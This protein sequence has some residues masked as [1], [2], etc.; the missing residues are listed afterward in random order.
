MKL[1]T[2]SRYGV[3][4]MLD[5]ALHADEGPVRLGVVAQRQGIGIKY[6]EQIIIPLKKANYITSVR[7]PK[8]GHLLSRPPEEITVG[9]IVKLLEG[10]LRLTRCI[11]Y[12]EECDRSDYCVTR[13]IWKE[14]TEAIHER[15]DAITF[16]ELMNRTFARIDQKECRLGNAGS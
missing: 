13:I 11:Q 2:R 10:G 8:G 1:S 6:L 3:R 9:Q 16:R 4:L 15:L 14:A 12:P 5:L 7:G